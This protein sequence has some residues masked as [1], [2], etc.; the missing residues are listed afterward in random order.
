[1]DGEGSSARKDPQTPG[2]VQT[3]FPHVA[4]RGGGGGG[5]VLLRRRRRPFFKTNQP[6]IDEAEAAWPE[7]VFLPLPSCGLSAARRKRLAKVGWFVA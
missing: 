3:S 6:R 1:M 4:N 2:Q 5:G 7:E